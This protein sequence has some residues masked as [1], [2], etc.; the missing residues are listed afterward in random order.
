MRRLCILLTLAAVSGCAAYGPT[1]SV[2]EQ[3]TAATGNTNVDPSY[4]G[5]GV[6]VGVGLGRWGGRSGGGIGIGLGF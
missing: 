3:G 2:D 1:E 6:N 5:P 4:P